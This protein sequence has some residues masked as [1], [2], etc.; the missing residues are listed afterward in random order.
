MRRKVEMRAILLLNWFRKA[1]KS[2]RYFL[3]R[4]L[5]VEK[6]KKKIKIEWMWK[7]FGLEPSLTNK[8]GEADF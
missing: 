6:E 4:T 7:K 5:Q 3:V 1:R 2:M 8:D